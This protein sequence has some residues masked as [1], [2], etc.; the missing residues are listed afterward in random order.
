MDAN[1][2]SQLQ[3]SKNFVAEFTK[4]M[5]DPNENES[6]K[7]VYFLDKQAEI[8]NSMSFLTNLV[9]TINGL[10]IELEDDSEE[11]KCLELA[12]GLVNKLSKTLTDYKNSYS[13]I[14]PDVT[15]EETTVSVTDETIKEAVKNDSSTKQIVKDMNDINQ[16]ANVA[17]VQEITH[18]ILVGNK[19]TYLKATTKQELNAFINEAADASPNAPIQLFTITLT[20]MPLKKKAVYTV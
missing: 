17:A 18:A 11:V 14:K 16:K 6:A 10:G 3:D 19:F 15:V 5:T 20:P 13:V 7:Q 4:K 2:I 8:K 1:I 9:K 12:N